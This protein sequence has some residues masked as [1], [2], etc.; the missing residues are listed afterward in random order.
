MYFSDSVCISAT[1]SSVTSLHPSSLV[2]MG[3]S[4][5]ASPMPR[6]TEKNTKHHWPDR[7]LPMFIQRC[8]IRTTKR[9]RKPNN[10]WHC[11]HPRAVK[12][13]LS[14]VSP[15]SCDKSTTC[16]RL[17]RVGE[18]C[19]E[20]SVDVRTRLSARNREKVKGESGACS[21][22]HVSPPRGVTS[23]LPRCCRHAHVNRMLDHWTRWVIAARMQRSVSHRSAWLSTRTI[24][25]PRTSPWTQT[26]ILGTL[27][28]SLPKSKSAVN[29]SLNSRNTPVPL[30]ANALSI[31]LSSVLNL[32]LIPTS[33]R[34]S[35]HSAVDERSC[36]VN[37]VR[38][39]RHWSD[40]RTL[41]VHDPLL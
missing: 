9:S 33:R 29:T 22:A 31:L 5:A 39:G 26:E 36:L 10:E 17:H 38:T 4:H 7:A 14:V 13:S 12:L 23:L 1:F 25:S 28:K 6:V 15:L 34:S 24:W 11:H 27:C 20:S 16:A 8:P 19:C 2:G 18:Q 32:L 40:S 41:T 35:R 21:V 3:I 30:V 37:R